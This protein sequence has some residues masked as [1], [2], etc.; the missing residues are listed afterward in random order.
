[1]QNILF[2]LIEY[3]QLLYS[4]ML[5]LLYILLPVLILA[6]YLIFQLVNWYFAKHEERTLHFCKQEIIFPKVYEDNN[7]IMFYN[8]ITKQ[9]NVVLKVK[10]V[11]PVI[12]R[13]KFKVYRT[14]ITLEGYPY[15]VNMNQ[16]LSFYKHEYDSEFLAN[17]RKPEWV[18]LLAKLQREQIKQ[19]L[20]DI[21][22]GLF[23]GI[24]IMFFVFPLL[25]D[26]LGYA[27]I[28]SLALKGLI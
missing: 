27:M 22:F 20:K 28:Q 5:E 18:K 8:S 25:K 16:I 17:F 13:R 9:P 1:M 3:L 6:F 24:T 15:V 23:I 2:N 26:Y 11:E 7:S 21:I 19:A 10:D 12:W 14:W 4:R